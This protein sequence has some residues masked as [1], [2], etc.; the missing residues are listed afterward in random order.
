MSNIGM[1]RDVENSE[2][3]LI[4]SWR[5]N[6]LIRKNMYNSNVISLDEHLK[7]WGEIKKS[8]CHKYF[9]FE[10]SDKAEG[11]VAFSD[12]N[13]NNSHAFWAFYASPISPRG[14]GAKMEYLALEYAFETLKLHKLSCEVLGYNMPVVNLHKKFG[15]IQEGVFRYHHFYENE[16]HDVYRLGILKDEW[17]EKKI[18]MLKRIQRKENK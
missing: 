17:K 10:I 5:N 7:W 4:L 6:P 15:F 13:K 9:I 14:I 3:E 2:L 16:Y 1:L 11:V 18:E 8:E 12:I